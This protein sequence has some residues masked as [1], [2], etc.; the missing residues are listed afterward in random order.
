MGRFV[1]ICLLTFIVVMC[2]CD[3][4]EYIIST[5]YIEDI[6]I[7]ASKIEQEFKNRKGPFHGNPEYYT[8]TVL[9]KAL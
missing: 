6:Q 7:H 3:R 2:G 1:Y 4:D 8:V 5:M 9:C